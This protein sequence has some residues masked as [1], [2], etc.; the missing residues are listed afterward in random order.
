MCMYRTVYSKFFQSTH[1]EQWRYASTENN[2]AG[3]ATRPVSAGQLQSTNWLTGPSFLP[4]PESSESNN[5]PFELI[6]SATDVELQPE[7]TTLITNV[8]E[9]QLN[10]KHFLF[11]VCPGKNNSTALTCC[12]SF[13]QATSGPKTLHEKTDYRSSKSTQTSVILAI[14]GSLQF[15][16]PENHQKWTTGGGAP[17]QRC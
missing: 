11:M 1:P 2:P 6:V 10:T 13:L 8:T 15:I 16:C 4:K 7:V 14:N 9:K 17:L 5:I 3:H 12:T